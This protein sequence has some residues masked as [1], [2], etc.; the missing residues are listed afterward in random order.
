MIT[1]H[2]CP[3]LHVLNSINPIMFKLNQTEKTII[4]AKLAATSNTSS[5]QAK[6]F[7][8]ALG[9]PEL[10]PLSPV[11]PSGQE[12]VQ[13]FASGGFTIKGDSRTIR[14]LRAAVDIE[15]D[16]RIRKFTPEQFKERLAKFTKEDAENSVLNPTKRALDID[17]EYETS[18]SKEVRLEENK[19]SNRDK[20]FAK[21]V[22][23]YL[24]QSNKHLLKHQHYAAVKGEVT[25]IGTTGKPEL[26]VPDAEL[27]PELNPS[28][29]TYHKRM[30]F[31]EF[32]KQFRL[33]PEHFTIDHFN[34]INVWD[35]TVVD[36]FMTASLIID[37]MYWNSFSH[38]V[39]K[40]MRGCHVTAD[41]F[42]I[43][44]VS[45]D[46]F[47]TLELKARMGLKFHREI[48]LSK[49]ELR[50]VYE[51]TAASLFLRFK[52]DKQKYL[53]S[54]CRSVTELSLPIRIEDEL[55]MPAR[56]LEHGE[57]VTKD[58]VI[59]TPLSMA[60]AV[61][62]LLDRR[63]EENHVEMV[64]NMMSILGLDKSVDKV[65]ESAADLRVA[66][67]NGVKVSFDDDAKGTASSVMS[68]LESLTNEVKALK[69]QTLNMSH[70]HKHSFDLKG[71]LTSAFDS[72]LDK[73]KV[74]LPSDP[75][76][77]D[78]VICLIIG[79][80]YLWATKKGYKKYSYM[81]LAIATGVAHWTE[82]DH[83]RTYCA[84]L[85][86][87]NLVSDL[88][89]FV[90]ELFG[91][92]DED[93]AEVEVP[94]SG[95]SFTDVVSNIATSYA[96]QLYVRALIAA[97][98]GIV[99]QCSPN[100][101][102][103]LQDIGMIQ[104]IVHGA[105]MTYDYMTDSFIALVNAISTPWGTKIFRT[106]Y[107]M[108]PE[109]FALT[110]KLNEFNQKFLTG[111]R[112]TKIDYEKFSSVVEAVRDLDTRI[113][114]RMD[115]RVYQEQ[116]RYC[117]RLISVL[118][119]KFK[120]LGVLLG[121]PRVA[122]YVTTLISDPGYG[123]SVL[124]NSMANALAP[125]VLTASEYTEFLTDP[126]SAK[127][128]INPGDE[129]QEGVKN[130]HKI[131]IIDDFLQMRNKNLD[132]K[133]CH[134]NFLIGLVNNN[135]RVVNK[136]FGDKGTVFFGPN[137]LI[138]NSN[139]KTLS[140][141]EM[142]VVNV[143][144]VGRRM[145]D[146]WS[147]TIKPEYRKQL[148]PNTYM[149]DETKCNGLDTDPY[150][151]V[152]MS[153]VCN[154][155]NTAELISADIKGS[156]EYMDFMRITG[157][158]Y[159]SH[160]VHQEG[161][162]RQL[163]ATYSNPKLTPW[164]NMTGLEILLD[165]SS[166]V[167]D[168]TKV[169]LKAEINAVD[170]FRIA[171]D[172]KVSEITTKKLMTVDWRAW[173]PMLSGRKEK[174]I[175]EFVA[176]M[177]PSYLSAFSA[178][179]SELAKMS[180][181]E[182]MEE[183]QVWDIRYKDLTA[184]QIIAK[185]SLKKAPSVV[186]RFSDA[187]RDFLNR[188]SE[189]DDVEFMY[190]ANPEFWDHFYVNQAM[191]V[192]WIT[193][194]KVPLQLDANFRI[195]G[196]RLMN[197]IDNL[198][199]FFHMIRQTF[200]AVSS[201]A[202]RIGK[203]MIDVIKSMY[204]ATTW[205]GFVVDPF[206]VM[207]KHTNAAIV[208]MK[209]FG[210]DIYN[211]IAFALPFSGTFLAAIGGALTFITGSMIVGN[212]ELISNSI[213]K[214]RF[215]PKATRAGRS[216]VS[217]AGV[218]PVVHVNEDGTAHVP[219][220]GNSRFWHKGVEDVE[221]ATIEN[222]YSLIYEGRILTQVQFLG[223][224]TFM[225]NDH[226][227][228]NLLEA[229]PPGSIFQLADVRG[230]LYDVPT[231]KCK[232]VSFE[233]HTDLALTTAN[234]TQ[235]KARPNIVD[236][237]VTNDQLKKLLTVKDL[238]GTLVYYTRDSE[239]NR[240][241]NHIDVNMNLK[242]T[243][244]DAT[245]GMM[246]VYHVEG[247]PSSCMS[248]LIVCDSR[249][250]DIYGIIGY[251]SAG[252]KNSGDCTSAAIIVTREMAAE[253][254]T[255]AGVE[256]A[257]PVVSQ[258]PLKGNSAI[259]AHIPI[260]RY[261]K[262]VTQATYNKLK[263]TPFYGFM[264][265]GTLNKVPTISMPYSIGEGEV[266]HPIYEKLVTMNN[267]SPAIN[268]QLA[269]YARTMFQMTWDRS[270]IKAEPPRLFTYEEA[271]NGYGLVGPD[272]RTTSV[273]YEL[274]TRGITK[275]MMYGTE[276][277]RILDTPLMESLIDECKA[278]MF[279]LERGIHPEYRYLGFLKG[280]LTSPQKLEKG[281]MRY[282]A[283]VD[284]KEHITDKVLFGYVIDLA[285]RGKIRNGFLMGVNPYSKDVDTMVKIMMVFKLLCDGDFK[286]FDLHFFRW[287]NTELKAFSRHVYYNATEAQHRARD[288]RIDMYA[289]PRHVVIVKND[290]GE[291]IGIEVEL[292][293][294]LS[295]GGTLT[296]FFGGFGNSL[297]NRYSYL[298]SWCDHI[299]VPQLDYDVAVHPKPDLAY[300]EENLHTFV[301]GDDNIVAFQEERYGYNC[302]KIQQNMAQ[303]GV[304]YTPSD[305]S[306]KFTQEWRTLDEIQIVK[307]NFKYDYKLGRWLAILAE[308]S[309]LGA[310]YWDE[311]DMKYFDQTLDTQLQ[312]KAMRGQHEHAEFVKALKIRAA[313]IGYTL[314]SPYLDYFVAV[315]FVTNSAYLPW[316][317]VSTEIPDVDDA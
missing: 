79:L 255:N 272:S 151:F 206:E 282:V 90:L 291:P 244:Y 223:G 210:S 236:K 315:N 302:L 194:S 265:E 13:T 28:I 239:G 118:Q 7:A 204:N 108:Y 35:G 184:D 30:I 180:D 32:V 252:N 172:L 128:A 31:E 250:K 75:Q 102:W 38:R 205:K 52:M 81:G 162:L 208:D 132:P 173:L 11:V 201:V 197:P 174:F 68:A 72:V 188:F 84:T 295:S 87:A 51:S 25:I 278:D 150:V 95:N 88:I 73:L 187:K 260:M 33:C 245:G 221:N 137:L 159:L 220:S 238:D 113:P 145:G 264:G 289:N 160:M 139:V 55:A 222:N 233:G 65:R 24:G 199:L 21:N 285:N 156:Y 214:V 69:G 124:S 104:K 178:K 53:L 203:T 305:K 58:G 46:G 70:E 161:V 309:I 89:P 15:V 57:T 176:K 147:V 242:F 237:H 107:T 82:N 313:E 261:V 116:V 37:S 258:V 155:H 141:D 45:N 190:D 101:A 99:I 67:E 127:V 177:K 277:P 111:A 105:E 169:P 4:D 308:E 9:A 60:E 170:V 39:P 284:W 189:M 307:R 18:K 209:S 153:M 246:L 125:I 299:G 230:K 235:L 48:D 149:L 152:P 298:I 23:T 314:S 287:L 175:D 131:I 10:K 122:P 109:A 303:I 292:E 179:I 56:D 97:V 98:F 50:S 92:S 229:T 80:V 181:S 306:E 17:N 66:S 267:P 123:K 198:D 83:V 213:A 59:L 296:Q 171:Q 193:D 207:R 1:T 182:L 192:E 63:E 266:I 218:K 114:K 135:E 103:V 142:S 310:L 271:I 42:G 167:V 120:V 283:G 96:P 36:E 262:P 256:L 54:H 2:P 274:R 217:K 294:I 27:E 293:G 129:Y 26:W 8:E 19:K 202:R 166:M 100:P 143:N 231:S 268:S 6:S 5:A 225:L 62:S 119:E 43:K 275:K 154:T 138:I 288:T 183:I 300:E 3:P 20:A 191:Y 263:K 126:K 121:G 49:K 146:V 247:H 64:P 254:L 257:H 304:K 232:F 164:P 168:K 110:D 71:M 281:L 195:A 211:S 74:I 316:G 117:Q 41:D 219:M 86:G 134:G 270:V 276:G 115:Q 133:I 216:N 311:H 273:G 29:V 91:S 301:L 280:E 200:V 130:G 215:H 34:E 140:P 312:E 240:I 22:K 212:L 186:E 94:M 297:M 185:T 77:R 157:V 14:R 251:H 112:V 93:E 227:L 47:H 44:I 228:T 165:L 196:S 144:A 234:G 248:P 241:A 249:F 16:E 243:K 85:F 76:A 78:L 290:D 224:F 279:L 148:G 136:A 226:A 317:Q 259:P 269:T 286:E 40:S 163:E 12:D 253:M 106:C 158:R 61:S